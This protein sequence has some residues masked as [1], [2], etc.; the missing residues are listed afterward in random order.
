V[1]LALVAALVAAVAFLG[2]EL[3]A[4]GLHYG[5][6]PAPRA[7]AHRERLP[8]SGID[9]VVQRLALGALNAAACVAGKSREELLLELVERG[10]GLSSFR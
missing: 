7:C 5:G 1:K 9:P 6:Q 8:G 3:V 10:A 2:A 4:G